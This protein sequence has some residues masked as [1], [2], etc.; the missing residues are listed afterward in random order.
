MG[1]DHA[2]S[3]FEADGLDLHSQLAESIN[4]HFN[5]AIKGDLIAHNMGTEGEKQDRDS[6]D[7]DF[8]ASCEYNISDSEIQQMNSMGMGPEFAQND[9]ERHF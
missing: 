8:V 5:E 9:E 3:G 6:S 7:E 4:K 2:P 1:R